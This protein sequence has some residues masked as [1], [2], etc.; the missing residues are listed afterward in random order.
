MLVEELEVG[1]LVGHEQRLD[2]RLEAKKTIGDDGLE[3]VVLGAE[4]MADGA[5][6]HADG[7]GHVVEG[8]ALVAELAEHEKGGVEDLAPSEVA[9]GLGGGFL[10]DRD[11]AMLLKLNPCSDCNDRVTACIS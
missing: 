1:A 2:F 9:A 10:E 3:E 7:A 5:G 4:V 6:A 8:G 11:A